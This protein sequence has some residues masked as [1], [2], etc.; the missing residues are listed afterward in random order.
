MEHLFERWTAVR[1]AIE[2]APRLL[3]MLDFDGTLSPIVE[4]PEDAI[5]LAKGREPLAALA[6]LAD[7]DIGIIS[8]RAAED[9]RARVG[10]DGVEYVGNHG[11]ERLRP[12]GGTSDEDTE[13]K[14]CLR[15]VTEAF[16]AKLGAI[17]G[18]L[19]E[20][21]GLTLAVHFRRTPASRHADVKQG[22]GEVTRAFSD[23]FH[24]S[25]GKMVFDVVPADEVSKGT[26]T[27]EMI[28]E[29][30]GV[31]KVLPIYCGDDT[32]DE[33]VFR[34]LPEEALTVSVGGLEKQSAAR[35]RV[36][37]PDEVAGFLDRILACRRAPTKP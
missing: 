11:R 27:L 34:A 23:R 12:G 9:V 25:E 5:L 13:A 18:I 29:R 14:Q 28:R 20:N 36:D 17:P 22:V 30:G 10:L 35:Y 8:G 37:D 26:T 16:E 32:T 15:A 3:L 6:G 19:L 21:K 31:E 33:T 7:V 24:V 2:A 1:R 4:R